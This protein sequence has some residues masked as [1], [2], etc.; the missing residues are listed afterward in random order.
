MLEC[1]LPSYHS[2]HSNLSLDEL[3][4][5]LPHYHS[6]NKDA[7]PV[8][9][10]D[11]TAASDVADS[12][13][14][15]PSALS[16]FSYHPYA[17]THDHRREGSFDASS[18]SPPASSVG[19]DDP[20]HP[21]IPVEDA[22]FAFSPPAANEPYLYDRRISE[23]NP[24]RYRAQQEQQHHH[25]HH[26]HKSNNPPL[27]TSLPSNSSFSDEHPSVH[28]PYPPRPS[29]SYSYPA[30]AGSWDSPHHPQPQLEDQGPFTT[31]P[32]DPVAHGLAITATSAALAHSGL[33]ISHGLAAKVNES[34]Y[35]DGAWMEPGG[36]RPDT[37]GSASGAL[38]H[39]YGHPQDSAAGVKS[40]DGDSDAGDATRHGEEVDGKPGQKG[41]PSKT[42]SFVAL[43]GNA[44]KKRPRRRYD[45]IERLYR[46]R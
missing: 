44:V 13:P 5:S 19:P 35:D 8:I 37:A 25:H 43:P 22:R 14:T 28:A 12:P 16:A 6:S 27:S 2:Y 40:D 41:K 38:G 33:S 11:D 17:L 15:P 46:C 29:S 10:H 21:R 24:A 34:Y 36:A 7:L 39:G 9:D 42:Y 26:H 45:E 32:V 31:N 18:V 3:A 4:L 20:H 30:N 23:P 1:P